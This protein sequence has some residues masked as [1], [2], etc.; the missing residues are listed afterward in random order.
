[1][2][3]EDYK[4]AIARINEVQPSDKAVIVAVLD[5]GCDITISTMG[6]V[7][8]ITLLRKKI[9]GENEKN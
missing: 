8:G 5:C 7:A 3:T 6:D 1:M 2:T 9:G 4:R